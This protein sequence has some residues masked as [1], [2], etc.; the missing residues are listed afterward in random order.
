MEKKSKIYVSG[1]KGMVGSA[2]LRYLNKD[3]YKNL[4]TRTKKEL[5]LVSQEQTKIFFE[6]QIP[7]YVFVAAAKVGGIK[8]NN[9]FRA[10][11]LYENIMIQNNIIHYAYKKGV[12]KLIFLGSACIYPRL[13]EQPIKEKSLLTG[14]L[15]ITN[16][17]Y[18]VAK[19]AGVKQCQSYYEQYGCNFF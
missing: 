18:A 1:H 2:L 15:E 12:K 13:A 6:E 4:I 9:T 5:N 11:F 17:P 19:I 8:A 3:G 7:E 10:Q 14:S 16:E